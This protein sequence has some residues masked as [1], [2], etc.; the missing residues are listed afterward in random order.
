MFADSATEWLP[1]KTTGKARLKEVHLSRPKH[2]SC[3]YLGEQLITNEV[4]AVFELVKNSYDADAKKVEVALENVSDPSRGSIVIKDAAGNGMDRDTVLNSWLE[5]GTSSKAR[6]GSEI[7]KSPGDRVLLGEKGIGRLAVHKLGH[8]TELIS[9][10][11]K[12]KTEM[13]L[14]IDWTRFE[15]SKNA[16]LDSIPVR[17]KERPPEVFIEKGDGSRNP[18]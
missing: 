18:K 1:R 12:S 17:W 16:D 11:I 10:A 5:L 2:D 13:K 6:S 4:V 8:K 15:N 3:F 14:D 7:R 9:R